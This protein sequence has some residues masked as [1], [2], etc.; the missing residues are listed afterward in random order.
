MPSKAGAIHSPDSTPATRSGEIPA[1]ESPHG[2]N[3]MPAQAA[4]LN[5]IKRA[6][7]VLATCIVQT[8]GESDHS[9]PRRFLERLDRAYARERD[10]PQA[11]VHEL[12]LLSWTREL[13]TGF[14]FATGQ[15]RPF[16][17]EKG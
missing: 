16:L 5:Q 10:D 15:G 13:L 12:E 17:D 7:A 4:D 14:N 8:L 9:F 3:V 1:G 11:G 2:I 6:T